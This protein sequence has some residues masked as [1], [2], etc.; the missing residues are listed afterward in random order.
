MPTEQGHDEVLLSLPL[1]YGGLGIFSHEDCAIH[2]YRAR[3][4]ASDVLLVELLD[5]PQP[6][7]ELELQCQRTR[8]AGMYSDQQ[9]LLIKQ[10]SDTE[11]GQY[12]DNLGQLARQWLSAIPFKQCT[13]LSSQDIAGGLSYRTSIPGHNT[14]CRHCAAQNI[15]DR[16]TIALA[17]NTS[18]LNCTNMSKRS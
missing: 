6:Q 8:C 7:E 3:T 1:R 12:V 9:D 13:T 5:L 10:L 2:A 4:E 15:L 11:F 14:V 16:T 18:T 17:A